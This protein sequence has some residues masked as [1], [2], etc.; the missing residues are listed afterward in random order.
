M[1]KETRE[2]LENASKVSQDNGDMAVS[3]CIDFVMA[4]ACHSVEFTQGMATLMQNLL[5]KVL[6]PQ[7]NP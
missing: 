1:K 4:A 2:A 5:E 7:D 6:F 3:A